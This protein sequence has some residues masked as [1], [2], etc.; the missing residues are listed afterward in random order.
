MNMEDM[1]FD[2]RWPNDGNTAVYP[3]GCLY[4]C[5]WPSAHKQYMHTSS[6]SRITLLLCTAAG[7]PLY[8]L[9]LQDRTRVQSFDLP[10]TCRYNMPHSHAGNLFIVERNAKAGHVFGVTR[11]GESTAMAAVAVVAS[12]TDVLLYYSSSSLE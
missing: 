4:Y 7:I 6:V 2:G 10:G 3:D 5:V 12:E 8:S 11:L 1:K 9:H